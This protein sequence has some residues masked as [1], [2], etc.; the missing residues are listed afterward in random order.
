MQQ[1]NLRLEVEENDQI[2]SITTTY[3]FSKIL[4]PSDTSTHGGFSVPKK[5]AD[6]CFPPL[7]GIL[8]ICRLFFYFLFKN[9]AYFWSLILQDMTQQTPAQEI[10]AKDLNGFEWHFRHIYRGKFRLFS[11]LSKISDSVA[12]IY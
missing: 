3:T 7:V 2:P 1:D 6:E 10:V 11:F 8:I 4:T 12:T 9:L 5:H